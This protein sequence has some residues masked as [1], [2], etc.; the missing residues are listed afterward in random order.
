MNIMSE[1]I[2]EDDGAIKWSSNNQ[3][4]MKDTMANIKILNMAGVEGE[5]LKLNDKV[6]KQEYNESVTNKVKM[7]SK[8][9]IIKY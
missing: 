5:V 9:Q 3:Y 4:L 6:F 7:I 8:E 2:V 1:A